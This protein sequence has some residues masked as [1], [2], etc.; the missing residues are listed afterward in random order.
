MASG[1]GL[2]PRQKLMAAS[3]SVMW[4]AAMKERG[5]DGEADG[6]R[7]GRGARTGM[8]DDSAAKSRQA[9]GIIDCYR[10]KSIEPSSDRGCETVSFKDLANPCCGT[11]MPM[12]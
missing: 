12:L 9:L 4:M 8:P 5:T 6:T 7:R 10:I 3:M 1:E 2:R 11:W